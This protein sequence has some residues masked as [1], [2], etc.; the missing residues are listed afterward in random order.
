MKLQA[1]IAPLEAA[2]GNAF[3]GNP[4]VDAL[5]KRAGLCDEHTFYLKEKQKEAKPLLSEKWKRW[6][7]P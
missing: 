1:K 2:A 3:S 5:A 7:P 4:D 6:L